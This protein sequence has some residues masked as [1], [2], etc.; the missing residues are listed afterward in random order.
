MA[1]KSRLIL[2]RLRAEDFRKLQEVYASGNSN[3][4][5]EAN[6]FL[7]VSSGFYQGSG[8]YPGL[9]IPKDLVEES[10]LI[11]KLISEFES[12]DRK[13]QTDYID[14]FKRCE[15]F[16]RNLHQIFL[17]YQEKHSE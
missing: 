8:N 11:L 2:T 13:D 17:D 5:F 4:G 14:L 7:A 12:G 1:L 10:N 15:D 6:D 16:E 9:E 3:W